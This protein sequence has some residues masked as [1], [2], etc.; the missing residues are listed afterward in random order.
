MNSYD[1]VS[2]LH[3]LPETNPIEVDGIQFGRTCQCFWSAATNQW[4]CTACPIL[5]TCQ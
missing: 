2:S 1:L 5:A 4:I 3:V